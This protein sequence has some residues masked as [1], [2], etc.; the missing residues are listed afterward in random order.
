MTDRRSYRKRT[1]RQNRRRS[2]RA[3]SGYYSRSVIPLATRGTTFPTMG[4]SLYSPLPMQL[5]VNLKCTLSQLISTGVDGRTAYFVAPLMATRLALDKWPAG[6][7]SLMRI[8]CQSKVM[9]ARITLKIQ[10]LE[11][12]GA[13]EL[14]QTEVVTGFIPNGQSVAVVNTEDLDIIRAIPG[15]HFKVI[16]SS[17]SNAQATDVQKVDCS[18]FMG[19]PQ[20]NDQAIMK[21]TAD[22]NTLSTPSPDDLSSTP[23]YIVGVMSAGLSGGGNRFQ[24]MLRLEASFDILLTDLRP[25]DVSNP[26]FAPYAVV[27]RPN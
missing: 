24:W 16:G 8:Y 5:R 23:T 3:P 7:L 26:D 9:G 14:P 4:R 13:G 11:T 21:N 6:Y 27:Q 17:S 22:G 18:T 10:A 20:T 15:T 12:Q 2:V 1:Y 25:M 19:Q